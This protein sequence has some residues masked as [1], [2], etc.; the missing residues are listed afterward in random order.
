MRNITSDSILA[1][2]HNE[3]FSNSNTVVR[4]ESNFTKLLLHGNLIAGKDIKGFF[5]DSCCYKTNTTKERLNGLTGVSI[6]QKKGLWY[7]NGQ[8]WNGQKIY[9]NS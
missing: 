3:K 1:F 7:L 2:N 5:I 8:L 4:I 9:I 6:Q